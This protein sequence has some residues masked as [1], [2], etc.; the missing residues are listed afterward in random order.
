[1]RHFLVNKLHSTSIQ[2]ENTLEA[3]D[4]LNCKPVSAHFSRGTIWVQYLCGHCFLLNFLR[5]LVTERKENEK[6]TNS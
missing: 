6:V 1:M 5:E 2:F 3:N 4:A